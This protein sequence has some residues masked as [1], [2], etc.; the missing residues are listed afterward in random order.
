MVVAAVPQKQ[1]V[2][3]EECFLESDII[4]KFSVGVFFN[5]N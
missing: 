3:P 4:R 5:L 1:R 2:C